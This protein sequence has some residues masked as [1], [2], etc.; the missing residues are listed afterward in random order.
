MKHVE[1]KFAV[2]GESGLTNIT[3]AE[4]EKNFTIVSQHRLKEMWEQVPPREKVSVDVRGT[5]ISI[6]DDW[7]C[8]VFGKSFVE[9]LI[10]LSLLHEFL[11][12]YFNKPIGFR[13]LSPSE[14]EGTVDELVR[15]ERRRKRLTSI[16]WFILTS[17][18]S[19]AIGYLIGMLVTRFGG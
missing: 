18:V 19:A 9:C 13:V 12:N 2:P 7:E 10:G 1:V 17:V 11:S 3:K 6:M 4:F 5:C 15:S 14:K 16:G 8:T